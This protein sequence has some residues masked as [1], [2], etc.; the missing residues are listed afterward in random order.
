[1][2]QLTIDQKQ[3]KSFFLF[4]K[5]YIYYFIIKLNEI[6]II[7]LHFLYKN[8]KLIICLFVYLKFRL[9]FGLT[10]TIILTVYHI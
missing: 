2:T 4:E 9:K 8:L 1:M 7:C 10:N 6:L 3:N 5:K